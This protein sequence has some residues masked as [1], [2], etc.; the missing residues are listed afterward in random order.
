MLLIHLLNNILIKLF[1]GDFL[2]AK[3]RNIIN[4]LLNILIGKVILHEFGN[5][6]QI[7]QRENFLFFLIDQREHGP[8][9]LLV[10]GVA[11]FVGEFFQEGL[12]VDPF[13]G[14]LAG[15]LLEGVV[16]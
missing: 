10:E 12:E 5:P 3:T 14:Q 9:S 6:A 2:L 15:Y 1:P 16:D 7:L 11:Q 4:D 13:A 8:A